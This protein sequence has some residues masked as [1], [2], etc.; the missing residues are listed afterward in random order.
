MSE[1]RRN[2]RCSNQ[3]EHVNYS[4]GNLKSLISDHR[5]RLCFT[6]TATC[7]FA[8]KVELNMTEIGKTYEILFPSV[9]N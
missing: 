9:R 7:Q 3:H 1:Q 5:S 8:T 2:S 4:H 6:Y